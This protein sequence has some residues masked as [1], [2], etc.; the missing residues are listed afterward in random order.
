M[1][2]FAP[3]LAVLVG[4]FCVGIKFAVD[5]VREKP[6]KASIT[7]HLWPTKIP[8][9]S[10]HTDDRVVSSSPAITN[11]GVRSLND[12]PAVPCGG[13]AKAKCSNCGTLLCS[14]HTERCGLCGR[15]FCNFCLSFHESADR[16]S[17]PKE[18]SA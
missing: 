7:S 1:K 8:L 3:T 4:A 9:T 6:R 18:K 15:A 13:S 11:C 14:A 10:A 16:R 17:M 2:S 5:L 12:A